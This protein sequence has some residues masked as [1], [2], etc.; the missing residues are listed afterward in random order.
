MDYLLESFI[1]CLCCFSVAILAKHFRL[2]DKPDSLR[3]KHKGE[4]PLGG[5]LAIFLSVFFG[6]ILLSIE[7]IVTPIDIFWI[8]LFSSL[9]LFVGLLDDI[10]P[11]PVLFRLIMQVLA[12]CG[13]IICTNLYLSNFGNL[14]G[15]GDIDLGIYGIPATIFMV[16][17]VC[18][19][20]NMLDGMD[21][22][23][24]IVSLMTLGAISFISMSTFDI[25]TT[26]FLPFI[27]LFVFLLF[28]LGF[29]GSRW[30]M[31]LGDSGSMWIGFTLAWLLIF[32]SQGDQKLFNP[33]IAL[34]L[35]PLPILDA[36]SIFIDRWRKRKSIFSADRSHIHHLFKD[37]GV[38]D[39]YTLLA[40]SGFSLLSISFALFAIK[41]SLK[42]YFIFYF[43]LTLCII[44][45]LARTNMSKIKK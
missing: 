16:V 25:P 8:F 23:V 2:I 26:F 5:G 7:S 12:S 20:F 38:K 31:F 11:L 4:V 10:K 19:A 36:L 14:F 40:L 45:L 21:G 28:N 27:S 43:F 44:Y 33:A 37:N 9:I 32:F 24:P 18:N 13:V 39:I 41:Y 15:L 6:N 34:F 42:D 17:G 30:K 1:A 35:I 3:K 22:L 29:L